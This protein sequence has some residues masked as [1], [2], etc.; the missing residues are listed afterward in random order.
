MSK[1]KPRTEKR[2]LVDRVGNF[3]FAIPAVAQF[4]ARVAAKKTSTLVGPS[5]DIPF[6]RLPKPLS[7]CRG[8][9]ITTGGIH[10]LTQPAFDMENPEGDASYRA[11]PANVD[12]AQIVI[13]HKYYDHRD[14]DQD[15]NVIF[16]LTHFQHLVEIGVVGTLALHHWGFMGHIEGAQLS[17]LKEQTAPEIAGKLRAKEVDFVFL[18]P[19]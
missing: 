12:P 18:T 7:Q 2:T 14:A 9:L 4:W 5:G 10:L 17:R 15:L 1:K 16:P 13:T 8:T 6:A 3:F 11:I 19:A